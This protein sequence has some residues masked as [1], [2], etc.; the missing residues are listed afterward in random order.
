MLQTKPVPFDLLSAAKT[1]IAVDT[2]SA[3]GNLGLR[4]PLQGYAQQTGLTLRVLETP[5]AGVTH[6]N[7]LFERPGSTGA[8]PLLLL[9]HTDTV[10]TGP[11]D[12]WT[13]TGPFAA[14]VDGDKLFGLGSAD[15]KTDLLCK[16]LAL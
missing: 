3:H 8:E 15:V 6:A 16:L 12:R 9:T 5:L 4:E 11:L 1:L 14:R 2:V 7:Y 10:P 13:E